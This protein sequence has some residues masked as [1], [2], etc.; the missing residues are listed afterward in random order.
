[1]LK[2]WIKFL[3][4]GILLLGCDSWA[5]ET[6]QT[7]TKIP[8]Y[9]PADPRK[10]LEYFE[11]QSAL[12]LEEYVASANMCRVLFKLPNGTEIKAL[13]LMEDS[14]GTTVLMWAVKSSFPEIAE[15]LRQAEAKE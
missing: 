9:D 6:F 14:N 12:I 11:S 4:F 1:M 13:C 3:G 15:I 7:K 5:G 8:G 2:R 10:V